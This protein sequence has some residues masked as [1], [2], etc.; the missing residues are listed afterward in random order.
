MVQP[1]KFHLALST[2]LLDIESDLMY[3]SESANL[4]S[5]S[6]SPWTKSISLRNLR[7][8]SLKPSTS[9]GAV[10]RRAI[11]ISGLKHQ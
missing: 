2:Q 9:Q 5:S 10:E 3:R 8:L 1:N 6:T 7:F 11:H 4:M